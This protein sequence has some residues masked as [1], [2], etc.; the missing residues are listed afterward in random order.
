MAGVTKTEKRI[1]KSSLTF[2]VVGLYWCVLILIFVINGL[3]VYRFSIRQKIMYYQQ[4]A[5]YS[6]ADLAEI[7]EELMPIDWALNYW[8]E[9]P[10]APTR[11]ESTD[12]DVYKDVYDQM[13]EK[14][15]FE[16]DVFLTSSDIQS[17]S[18]E[19]QEALSKYYYEDIRQFSSYIKE[20]AKVVMEGPIIAG[21][22]KGEP[23]RVFFNGLEG[24]TIEPGEVLNI[25]KDQLQ[26][27]LDDHGGA[28]ATDYGQTGRKRENRKW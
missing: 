27:I 25:P 12:I 28:H 6:A 21:G 4:T 2:Q 13:E 9:H 1:M 15:G 16:W 10:D 3:L 14:Y 22:R 20:E 24:R 11:A 26:K 17:M 23:L 18:P 8:N 7:I 5:E 19:E